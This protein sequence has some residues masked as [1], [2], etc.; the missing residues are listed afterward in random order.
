MRPLSQPVPGARF[1]AQRGFN[2]VETLV[3]MGL[4]GTVLLSIITLFF[5][6]RNNVSSGKQMTHAVSIGTHVMED[7]SPL[8]VRKLEAAFNFNLVADPGNPATPLVTNTV[9]GIS[10]P[11]SILR[12][13]TN[14]A[15]DANPPNFL[16]QWKALLDGAT[17]SWSCGTP[18][19]VGMVVAP[20]TA[21]GFLYRASQAGTSSN[22]SCNPGTG[23]PPA[24]PTTLGGTVTDGSVVWTTT[25]ID[26]PRLR[27]GR[28][29]LVFTP[30]D[31]AQILRM[32]AVVSW[33]EHG[34]GAFGSRRRQVLMETVKVTPN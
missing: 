17:T 4:L 23:T 27:N 25:R 6:G 20:Q 26:S 15:S 18:Y 30:T 21:N 16:D 22:T 14:L 19:S 9:N 24:W 31:S 8:T 34:L 13:T 33:P 3:A 11:N 10:Y 1:G 28:V 2:L 29:D 12:S 32:H 7:L 5:F